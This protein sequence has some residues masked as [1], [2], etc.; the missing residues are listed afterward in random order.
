MM[1]AMMAVNSM[2]VV[3]IVRRAITIVSIGPVVTVRVIAI[4]VRIIAIPIR[5]IP[6]SY[7]DASN[8]N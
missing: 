4:S 8:S 7:S 6:K 3:A 5:R 2:P 1:V